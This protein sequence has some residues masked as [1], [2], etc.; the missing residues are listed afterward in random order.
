MFLTGSKL[1]SI[2][3]ILTRLTLFTP[4]DGVE[5]EVA[6]VLCQKSWKCCFYF[7]KTVMETQL[8]FQLQPVGATSLLVEN[9]PVYVMARRDGGGGISL[10]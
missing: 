8:L 9:S 3:I 2:R 1:K 7:A 10:N 6:I 4:F 5:F